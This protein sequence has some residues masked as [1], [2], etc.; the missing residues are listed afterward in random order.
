MN[1]N[2]TIQFQNVGLPEDILRMKHH[3]VCGI[4]TIPKAHRRADP[5]DNQSGEIETA[6]RGL[7]YEEYDRGKTVLLCEE[8]K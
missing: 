4:F 3:G 7:T 8:V 5:F 6:D 2:D 1:I